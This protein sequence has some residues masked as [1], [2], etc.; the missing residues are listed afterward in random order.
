[1]FFEMVRPMGMVTV[2]LLKMTRTRRRCKSDWHGG[3]R[4]LTSQ[5]AGTLAPPNPFSAIELFNP[6]ALT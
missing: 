3:A 4:L 5:L 6:R 2:R 1:M